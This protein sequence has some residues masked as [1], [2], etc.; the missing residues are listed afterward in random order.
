[1]NLETMEAYIAPSG[2]IDT[3][4]AWEK[5]YHLQTV[6][7]DSLDNFLASC[8]KI[9]LTIEPCVAS[10]NMLGETTLRA[11]AYDAQRRE[12]KIFYRLSG[13]CKVQPSIRRA[14]G[15]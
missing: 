4:D 8:E 10:E 14:D 7:D 13:G 3:L 2:H 1:M 5:H 9:R 11:R 12:Y 15:F 6:I